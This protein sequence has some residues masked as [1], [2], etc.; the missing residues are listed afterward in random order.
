MAAVVAPQAPKKA[1]SARDPRLDVLRGAA[2]VTIFVNHVPGNFYESLTIR[3]WG[4]SDAAE[5]FV[6]MSGVSA[7]LAY[8]PAFRPG[9]EVWSGLARA[10]GRAWTLYLVHLLVTLAVLGIAAGLALWFHTPGLLH[11]NGVD[12]L[13]GHPLQ[14]LVALP[15]LLHQLGY[16]NILPLYFVLLLA[17]PG[18]LW[19]GWRWPGLLMT[20]SGM[21]WL[22]AGT[23]RLNVPTWPAS[24]GWQFSP[25]S[26]Q[27]LFVLGLLTGIRL[28]EGRRLVPINAWLIGITSAFLAMALVWRIVPAVGGPLNH[29]LMWLDEAGLPWTVTAFHK[30][31]ETAPRLFHALALAYLLSAIPAV[32]RA[33]ASVWLSPLALLGR[34]ALPAFALGS[35]LAMLLQGIKTRTGEDLLLDSLMLA[36]GLSLQFALA[37]AKDRWPGR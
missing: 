27:I 18:L 31:W 16:I 21:L 3:N 34:Q 2:L 17:A 13:L 15:L 8:G 33:C 5:A 6:L 4:F 19:L 29:G 35:V 11:M 28:R 25:L 12:V 9:G 14:T 26:W 30:V 23:F 24:G 7:G 1:R 36:G 37:W 10:W 32:R 20:A 22:V